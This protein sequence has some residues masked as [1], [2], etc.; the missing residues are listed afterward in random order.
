MTLKRKRYFLVLL[1][2]VFY[3]IGIIG[4]T[5]KH[6]VDFA[7]LTPLNLIVSLV[8]LLLS[9]GTISKK[10]WIDFLL[11]GTIG[12]GL[13]VIGANTHWFFGSYG[14][15]EN[16]GWSW[17]NVPVLMSVNWILMCFSS[18]ALVAG[19]GSNTLL[20]A[21]LASLLM[22]GLDLLIEPVAIAL[23]FWDWK[24]P[25]PP[26][27]NY[28]CWF[29]LSLPLNWWI[30]YRKSTVQNVVSVSLFGLLAVFFGILNCM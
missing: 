10:Q 14:Y 1:L 23:D 26:L 12:F 15:G 24:T 7:K 9:F 3:T 5:G 25:Q 6:N 19:I 22:T 30:L 21:V 13:E 11:V 17:L 18:T 16:L 20:Q 4:L 28:I 27:F 8:C 29:V 2:V